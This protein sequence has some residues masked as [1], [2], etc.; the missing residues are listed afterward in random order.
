MI[1]NI[2]ITDVHTALETSKQDDIN[3]N[4]WVSILDP[5][6]ATTV[7]TLE[8]N[9]KNKNI[10]FFG[11]CF[12]DWSDE[13]PLPYDVNPN[14]LPQRVHI[15]KLINFLQNLVKSEKKYNLGINCHAGMCRSTA[16]GIIAWCLQGCNTRDA[17][18]RII[19]VRPI[20][21]P[22][23]RILSFA[24]ELLQNDISDVVQDWKKDITSTIYT[25]VK[26]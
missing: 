21:W 1:E 18:Q 7:N 25:F 19:D 10:E 8:Q 17:L 4:V 13:Q 11:Q 22:N 26:F 15:D 3:Q 12:Y 6:Q 16:A 23:Q 9:F 20:A 5:E 14:K 2:I 24:Q